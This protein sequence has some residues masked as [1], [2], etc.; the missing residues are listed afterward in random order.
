MPDT[1][2][3]GS[4]VECGQAAVVRHG[5]EK[6]EY[7]I[8][9]YLDNL[10]AI[11]A[12]RELSAFPKKLGSANR[13]GPK[14]AMISER[15]TT[16]EEHHDGDRVG[17]AQ[18]KFGVAQEYERDYNWEGRKEAQ[19][20]KTQCSDPV[21]FRQPRARARGSGNCCNFRRI[22]SNCSVGKIDANSGGNASAITRRAI[23]GSGACRIARSVRMITSLLRGLTY[24]GES[25]Q[26]FHLQLT[27]ISFGAEFQC[28]CHARLR[29]I[30]GD[31]Q[32]GLM[33]FHQKPFC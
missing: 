5:E 30:A 25:G 24:R 29:H 9:M 14:S 23:S 7:I 12:G 28:F 33:G 4:Y 11:A 21:A 6:G 1:T 15:A 18:R 19:Q 16:A 3:Y 20:A 8:G 10:P 2:G 13:P 26:K 22:S 31:T 17:D 32:I 27:F